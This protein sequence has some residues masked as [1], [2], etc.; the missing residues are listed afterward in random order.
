LP[1][2][3]NICD[4]IKKK[5][6][7][8]CKSITGH[9]Q[10]DELTLYYLLRYYSESVDCKHTDI[11]KRAKML[12]HSYNYIHTLVQYIKI[13]ECRECKRNCSHNKNIIAT[14]FGTRKPIKQNNKKDQCVYVNKKELH[15][16]N[17]LNYVGGMY[18]KS[19]RILMDHY[20]YSCAELFNLNK[21]YIL[22]NN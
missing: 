17:T 3:K 22:N 6:G 13:N 7:I 12:L 21:L 15:I 11:T 19:N 14:K 9:K 10:V 4:S 20:I 18:N 16:N 2:N 5:Y 8:I 1:N